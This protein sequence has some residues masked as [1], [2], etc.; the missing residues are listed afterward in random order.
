MANKLFLQRAINFQDLLSR[1]VFKCVADVLREADGIY[2]D[3][4]QN[5]LPEYHINKWQKKVTYIQ[6]VAR[7]AQETPRGEE[8]G[9]RTLMDKFGGRSNVDADMRKE[10]DKAMAK[11]SRHLP[12]GPPLMMGLPLPAPPPFYPR[13]DQWSF[14]REE[15]R[16]FWE[17]GRPGTGVKCFVCKRSGHSARDCRGGQA[18]KRRGGPQKKG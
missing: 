14:N 15:P 16:P 2:W 3:A 8:V 1:G 6:Y 10:V 11:G 17:Q 5:N 4:K 12:L 13:P 7:V 9:M 18:A